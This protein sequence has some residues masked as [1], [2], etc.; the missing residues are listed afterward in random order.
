MSI[1]CRLV[2]RYGIAYDG[3]ADAVMLPTIHGQV[4]IL[5]HH[6]R[7]YT[8]M[9]NGI[10]TVKVGDQT[11]EFTATGGFVQVT[12][13]EIRILA[14]ASEVVDEIDL[15]RAEAA[16]NRALEAMK[17]APTKESPDFL[18]AMMLFRKSSLRIK[19]AKRFKQKNPVAFSDKRK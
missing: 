18:K 11:K 13:D 15:E 16:R 14:D 17:Q 5:P 8:K 1:R 19:A 9:T 3:N 7:M 4:G 10:I 12:T 6:I 2:S